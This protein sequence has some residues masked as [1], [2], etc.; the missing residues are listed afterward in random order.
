MMW[1]C[2]RPCC[3]SR[4]S[5]ARRERS[6][7]SWSTS[8]A[9]RGFRGYIDAAGNAVG[10]RG[11]AASG[12]SLLLGHMD[13]VAGDVYVRREENLLFGRGAVDAKGPLAAFIAAASSFSGPGAWW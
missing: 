5:P 11:D 6:P 8:S 9:A 2:S 1:R 7:P 4:A 10:E 13:T 12:P 3:A